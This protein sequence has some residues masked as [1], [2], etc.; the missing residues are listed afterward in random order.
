MELSNY[1]WIFFTYFGDI[2]YWLG[3][4]IS[5]LF[6]YP[7]LDKKNKKKQRW[8]IIYLLPAVLLSY[9]SSFFLKLIFQIPRVC[10]G[11][12]YCPSTYAFPSAHSAIAFSF[13]TIVLLYF[14]KNPRI[15]LSVFL[16]AILISYSRIALNVHTTL[17][18]AGGILTGFIISLAWYLFFKRIESGKNNLSFYFRKLIH[19]SGIAIIFLYLNVE[20]IY[21]FLFMLSITLMFLISEIFRL[22][23]I[24]FPIIHEISN[25]CRKKEEKG[26][27]LEPFFFGFSFCV[28]ILLPTK[29]FLVGSLPLVIGDSFAGLVGHTFSRHKLS[30]NKAKTLE[31]SLAFF[32][33]TLISLLIFFDLKI[34]LLL[35]IFSTLLESVLRKYENLILP[36]SC[37]AFYALI[38]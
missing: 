23:K 12:D 20:R 13:F 33:L 25:F 4:T 15:Y 32:V 26:F 11:Y 22:K 6:I 29:L 24:Y 1:I 37:V 10:I 27:L 14:R 2:A 17:D 19:L 34:S 7:F 21:I 3:F 9:L 16:L 35:S 38:A 36:F 5:F 30:Y 28:L 18:I 31:G 8:I